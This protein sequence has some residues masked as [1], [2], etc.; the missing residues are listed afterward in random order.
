M[1]KQRVNQQLWERELR[2]QEDCI[3]R[4][5][6]QLEDSQR[7]LDDANQ[8]LN[9]AGKENNVLRDSVGPELSSPS[10]FGGSGSSGGTGRSSEA[11]RLPPAPG[12][13]NIQQGQEFIPGSSAPPTNV[14]PPSGGKSSSRAPELR[15]PAVTPASLNTPVKSEDLSGN[16]LRP[17]ERMNPDAEVAR[18][19]L[20][21]HHTGGLNSDGKPGDDMLS[22]AIE[23][24][25]A[26]DQRIL[27]PGDLKIVLVDP[28]LD[29]PEA[30]LARWEFDSDEVARHVRRNREGA[31]YQ[32]ELPWQTNPTHSDLR[33]FVRFSTFDGRRLEAN[34]PL[35]VDLGSGDR[36][37][38]GQAANGWKM[39]PIAKR[40]ESETPAGDRANSAE[41]DPSVKCSVYES[42]DTPEDPSAADDKPREAKRSKAGWSP[43]R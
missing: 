10:A 42:A 9:T 35:E 39:A 31:S 26:N 41:S 15:G 19:I 2:L 27:A 32:F 7:Q 25:D 30:K 8:R 24:R 5:K 40:T 38:G 21:P 13:P 3:Y 1:Y 23:Q 14:P 6:W 34:A 11:P 29:G 18:I 17:S 28:A 37:A 16:P 12:L 4:L 20:N 22:I 36:G 33:V 43:S